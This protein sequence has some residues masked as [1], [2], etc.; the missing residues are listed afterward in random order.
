MNAKF[1]SCL[2]VAQG[3]SWPSLRAESCCRRSS[4]DPLD[5]LQA[6]LLHIRVGGSCCRNGGWERRILHDDRGGKP[7]P[8]EI[9]RLIALATRKA[10]Q[11]FPPYVRLLRTG[12]DAIQTAYA[13]SDRKFPQLKRE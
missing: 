8:D 3:L 11:V 12:G 7:I 4:Q 6:Y 13:I 1:Y 5:R 2:F 10:W 9:S